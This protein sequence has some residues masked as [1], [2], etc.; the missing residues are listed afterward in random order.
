MASRLELT[1]KPYVCSE[2]HVPIGCQV[3]LNTTRKHF[4]KRTCLHLQFTPLTFFQKYVRP[5]KKYASTRSTPTRKQL[6]CLP[7]QAFN[8]SLE[9]VSRGCSFH[10]THTLNFLW[11]YWQMKETALHTNTHP[12]LKPFQLTKKVTLFPGTHLASFCHLQYCTASNRK[13]AGAWEQGNMHSVW[14]HVLRPM[15]H[16]KR[17]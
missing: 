14:H 17:A 9:T 13:L 8:I 10:V 16:N 1:H 3:G 6:S 4:G 7:K 15:S 5:Y 11:E 2:T 12:Y